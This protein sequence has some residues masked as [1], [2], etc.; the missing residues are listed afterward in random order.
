MQK[1]RGKFARMCVELYLT[2]PLVLEFNVEGQVLSVVYESLGLLC[3][4][5]GW[6]GHNREGCDAFHS[7]NIEGGMDVEGVVRIKRMT[8]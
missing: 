8:L 3:T 5:C 6:F 4:T 2:K 1:A 7:K